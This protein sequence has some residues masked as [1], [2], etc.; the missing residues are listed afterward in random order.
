MSDLDLIRAVYP[1]PTATPADAY[2]NV[3]AALLGRIDA[4]G[5]PRTIRRRQVLL[6][7]V[8]LAA[9]AALAV[10]IALTIGGPA[11]ET[12]SAASVLRNAAA[13]ALARNEPTL[14]PGQ[15]V[16]TKSVTAYLATSTDDG[17]SYLLPSVRETWLSPDGGGWLR[18]R[19][20]KP[21]FLSDRDRE[22]W[23]AAG[24]PP[25]AGDTTTDMALD[26]SDGSPLPPMMSL[27]LPA[28]PDALYSRLEHDARGHGNGLYGQM[29][30][31]IGDALRENY[32]TPAQ[33][34]ALYEVAARLP[35]IE[36]VGAVRDSQGR[37]G[38]AVAMDD[39][40]RI[41]YELVFDPQ[42]WTL[43][44]EEQ[45]VLAANWWR[46]PVGTVIGHA[47]YLEHAVV[48]GLKER[49]RS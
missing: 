16:Y 45:T 28:D 39:V 3:R 19:S 7:V 32:T 47:T 30:Q 18:E 43:L 17:Y 1:A 22:R 20:G 49:P 46:Y 27:D 35:G 24:R 34:A 9:A 31:L 33:Q 37:D 11:A 2:A 10:G 15:Y 40:N 36:L 5:A 12:A 4:A 42:T 29:F 25:L 13:A 8:G 44:A 6:P 41:R 26:N 38:V 21:R 48:D 14:R 23:V